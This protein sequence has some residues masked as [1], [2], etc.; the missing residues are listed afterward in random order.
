MRELRKRLESELEP[1]EHIR[2]SDVPV[3]TAFTLSSFFALLF[4]L[5]CIG[6]SLLWMRELYTNGDGNLTY[7]LGIPLFLI[8][9]WLLLT[10]LRQRRR[11]GRTLYAITDRRA[12]ILVRGLWDRVESYRSHQL[13]GVYRREGNDGVGDVVIPSGILSDGGEEVGFFRIKNSS[14]VEGMLDELAEQL[15]RSDGE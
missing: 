2:W 12:M 5:P 4:G 3:P 9:V 13:R 10:P 15:E 6:F 1:G 7:V 11:L 8:G 14:E